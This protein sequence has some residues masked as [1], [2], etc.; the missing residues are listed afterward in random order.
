[1]RAVSELFTYN[2]LADYDT[3]I[4]KVN[5]PSISKEEA[6][7]ILDFIVSETG[8]QHAHTGYLLDVME[9]T[10]VSNPV[11]G[12]LMKSLEVVRKV[13]NYMVLVMS[14]QL[15]N[16]IMLA[17]P[18]MFDYYAVFHSTGDALKFIQKHRV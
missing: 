18:E 6:N 12:V 11:I 1:M 15:L 4:G 17:H 2:Y 14:E 16:D 5:V 3:L 9:I 10:E 8:R 13:N 7:A